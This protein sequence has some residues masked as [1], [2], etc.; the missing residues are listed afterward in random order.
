MGFHRV[1]LVGVDHDYSGWTTGAPIHFND[2]NYPTEKVKGSTIRPIL[3]N[4]QGQILVEGVYLECARI[5]EGNYRTVI[6]LNPDSLL[7]VFPKKEPKYH[8]VY[9]SNATRPDTKQATRFVDYARKL[10]AKVLL[11]LNPKRNV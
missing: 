1:Y 8:A 9:R 10:G 6:N 5:W 11:S 4:P 2:E 7:D 3:V